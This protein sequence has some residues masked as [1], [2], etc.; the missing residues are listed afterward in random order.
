VQTLFDHGKTY[1]NVGRKHEHLF[2]NGRARCGRYGYT[3]SGFYESK[4]G[5]RFYRCSANKHHASM[6]CWRTVRANVLEEQVWETIHSNLLDEPQFLALELERRHA[7]AA[8]QNSV[9]SHDAELIKGE[10]DAEISALSHLRDELD[11]KLS[12]IHHKQEQIDGAVLF[13]RSVKDQM[14]TYT[15]AEKRKVVEVLDVRV[16]YH[17]ARICGSIS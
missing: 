2:L 16:V 17:D 6:K 12:L 11:R 5:D 4:R 15:I 3:L 13:V 14:P 1:A 8:Q 7:G 10:I 9:T